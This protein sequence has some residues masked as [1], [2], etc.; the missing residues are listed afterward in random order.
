MLSDVLAEVGAQ[1]DALLD[2]ITGYYKMLCCWIFSEGEMV[3]AA[4][5]ALNVRIFL[6][7]STWVALKLM[8][9]PTSVLVAV[10]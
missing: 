10:K 5:H 8:S 1:D 9:S 4:I 3:H 2:R 7:T 6:F